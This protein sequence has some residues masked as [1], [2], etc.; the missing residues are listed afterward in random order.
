VW[1]TVTLDAND[2]LPANA[3]VPDNARVSDAKAA[4]VSGLEEFDTTRPHPARVYDYYLDGKDNFAADR[5]A[6]E[7]VAE[8]APWAVN[9]ARGNRAFL[10][11]AV[12]YL[13]EAGVRQFLDI[14]CGLPASGNVHEIA[15][16]VDPACRVVYVDCDPIVLIH[17]RALLACDPRTITVP[18]DAREPAAI[19]A[20]PGV[21][22]HFDFEQPI[23]VLLVAVLHFLASPGDDPAA[24]VAAFREA[25]APGS[26]VVI[27]HVADLP[28]GRQSAERAQATREAAQ[29]YQEL[30]GPFALRSRDE[31]AG[32]FAG[33]DLVEPGLVGV[34]EWRPRRNRPGP[35]V[36]VLAGIGRVCDPTAALDSRPG[37]DP[38]PVRGP[39]GVPW[40]FSS[41]RSG[42]SDL[43][44]VD[45]PAT[46][47]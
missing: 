27:S 29:L 23:A 30:A 17:A 41:A 37:P 8:L 6:A 25:L 7:Q 18:G 19:L 13:A 42:L 1:F 3:G 36:P 46:V 11:R 20:D 39:G 44:G 21:R 22:A 14:G 16:A 9:S 34:H 33:L 15:Q 24:V 28:D 45:Q 12:R 43:S 38:S 31:I 2:C 5:Q 4:M 32:L 10:S 47:V 35:P 26:F 40:P